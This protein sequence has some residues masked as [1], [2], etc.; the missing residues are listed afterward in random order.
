MVPIRVL[1]FQN[2]TTVV[3]SPDTVL[4]S[5]TKLT[6]DTKGTKI[7]YNTNWN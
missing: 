1:V 5:T 4:W 3:T 7:A 6:K 2:S